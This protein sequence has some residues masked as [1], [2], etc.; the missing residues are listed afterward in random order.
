MPDREESFPRQQAGGLAQR[1]PAHSEFSGELYLAPKRELRVA[2][3]PDW[4]CTMNRIR[5]TGGEIFLGIP[6]QMRSQSPLVE[7]S[8]VSLIGHDF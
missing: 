4:T 2:N 8:F 1:L 6:F 7:S 5:D 3:I